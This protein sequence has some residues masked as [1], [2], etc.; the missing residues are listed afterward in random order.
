LPPKAAAS[1]FMLTSRSEASTAQTGLPSTSAIK[2]FSM[3][4]GAMPSASAAR[5]PM[6]SAAGS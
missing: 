1:F 6:R 2:V 5:K 3:R 4:R